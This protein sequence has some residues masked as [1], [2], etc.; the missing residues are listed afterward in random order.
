MARIDGTYFLMVDYRHS[1][2]I[3]THHIPI[4]YGNGEV[5]SKTLA[6][7]W[8]SRLQQKSPLPMVPELMPF[9]KSLSVI[10][11]E[12]STSLRFRPL[13]PLIALSLI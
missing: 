7:A 2:G 6:S 12:S 11:A 5:K 1:D 8:A 9:G 10:W 3:G 13:A 4:Q